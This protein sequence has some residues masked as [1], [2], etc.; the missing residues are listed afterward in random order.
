[1]LK[2]IPAFWWFTG[3]HP[4]Y[5]HTTDT[6]DK[7]NYVKMAK[8]LRLAYLTAW[9]FGDTDVEPVFVANPGNTQSSAT[10]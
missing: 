5:H 3:F 7:I 6:A 9:H 10:Q 8:I 2:D 4:D 1:V